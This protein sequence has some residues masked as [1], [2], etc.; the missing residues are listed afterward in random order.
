MGK[1]YRENTDTRL[2][3]S[4]KWVSGGFQSTPLQLYCWIS[5]VNRYVLVYSTLCSFLPLPL[6]LNSYSD[7]TLGGTT[8]CVA[9]TAEEPMG[10][11]DTHHRQEKAQDVSLCSQIMK[12]RLSTQGKE[13]QKGSYWHV[14]CIKRHSVKNYVLCWYRMT[15]SCFSL[16]IYIQSMLGI[17]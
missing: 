6:S 1:C 11:G 3:S 4:T 10:G 9:D 8:R 12:M 15:Q 14:I 5:A 13:K 7:V 16:G 17:K 2:T